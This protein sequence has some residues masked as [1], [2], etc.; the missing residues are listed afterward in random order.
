[1]KIIYRETFITRL[2]GQIEFI[3]KDSPNRAIIFKE[4]LIDRIKLIPL[5]PYVFR[6]SIYFNRIDICD[7]LFKG[8]TLIFKVNNDTIDVFEFIKH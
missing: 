6:K 7:L 2:E 8:Y 4:Q 1:M 3:A 5:N